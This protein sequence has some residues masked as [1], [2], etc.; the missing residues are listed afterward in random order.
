MVVEAATSRNAYHQVIW[1]FLS[2]KTPFGTMLRANPYAQQD[3]RLTFISRR[4]KLSAPGGLEAPLA[5]VT[6]A[7]GDASRRK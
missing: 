3:L 5:V 4:R 2:R 7:R 1:I 6:L